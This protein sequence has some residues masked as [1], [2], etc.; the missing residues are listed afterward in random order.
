MTA[1]PLQWGLE[2]WRRR[3]RDERT[4]RQYVA[5]QASSVFRE[6]MADYDTFA[7]HLAEIPES[8]VLIGTARDSRVTKFPSGCRPMSSTPIGWCRAAPG[9]ARPSS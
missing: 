6:I 5:A 4:A 1:D 2:F 9:P 7:E 3:G 8:A